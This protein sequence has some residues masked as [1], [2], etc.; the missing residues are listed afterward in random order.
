MLTV[1]LTGGRHV[2]D[3]LRMEGHGFSLDKQVEMTPNLTSQASA[4]HLRHQ[5]LVTSIPKFKIL[6][7]PATYQQLSGRFIVRCSLSEKYSEASLP[8][9]QRKPSNLSHCRH[10]G[11]RGQP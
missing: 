4:K 1:I 11:R 7:V 5:P 2:S 6:A 8:V 9:A 10:V 3:C